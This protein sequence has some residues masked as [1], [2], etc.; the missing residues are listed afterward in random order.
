MRP[1]VR[2]EAE[3]GAQKVCLSK[4]YIRLQLGALLADQLSASETLFML[5][6]GGKM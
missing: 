4:H 3:A 5:A 6:Q 2:G 1:S